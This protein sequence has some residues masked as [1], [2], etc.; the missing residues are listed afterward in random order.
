MKAATA[1]HGPDWYQMPPDLEKVAICRLS[2]ARATPACREEQVVDE[3]PVATTGEVDENG[4]PIVMPVAP[5]RPRNQVYE[6]IFPIGA[7][8]PDLC[9]IHG[10]SMGAPGYVAT[11]ASDAPATPMVDAALQ[12]SSG[13]PVM[14]IAT[15]GSPAT[16]RSANP[17]IYYEPVVG[18]DGVVRMV[19]RQRW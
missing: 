19:K 17:R 10:A 18:P 6:D 7:V 13:S 2:G 3:T 11:D 15:S 4:L 14:P 8:P 5:P 12:Q 16:V 9:P 1:G